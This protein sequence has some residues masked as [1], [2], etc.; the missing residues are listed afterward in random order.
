MLH[1]LAAFAFALF[2]M[3]ASRADAIDAATQKGVAFL[4]QAQDER[5]A[6]RE[7]GSFENALTGLSALSM[8]ALGHLPTDPDPPGVSVRRAVNFLL[9]DT[10]RTREGYFGEIDGSRMY[11]HGIIALLLSET[12]GMA[13]TR[14]E[15][16]KLRVA[17]TQAIEL[18]LRS[19]ATPKTSAAS[20][21]GWRYKPNAP[22][23]DLSISIWQLLALRSAKNA[24][25]DVPASSIDSA[26]QFLRG[27]YKPFRPGNP[28][29]GFSYEPARG[30]SGFSA[31][32]AGMLAL[33][34]CGQY[35][36]AETT[37][38]AEQMLKTP[39]HPKDEPWFYYGMYYYA[40]G[41][42]QRGGLPAESA[43]KLVSELL[44]P[45]QEE[46]GSW[47]QTSGSYE[48]KRI[49]RTALALLSLSVKYHYLPIYQR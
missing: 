29:A 5:G 36:A 32:C 16:E 9:R 18:I 19:Q 30:I 42:H 37:A 8:L 24:G 45:L 21:G 13:P 38:V 4:L 25:I 11:G 6:I 20:Q 34:I 28:R 47:K 44:L 7:N 12:L 2:P 27:C 22:D 23:A 41:M 10:Q 1:V 14:S 26:V 15:D 40:Q 35:E 17:C 39:P 33:Q 49:Y 43:K 46:D 3:N 31:S 48:N